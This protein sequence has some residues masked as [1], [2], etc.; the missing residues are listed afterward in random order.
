MGS[1]QFLIFLDIFITS[2]GKK[3]HFVFKE[4]FDIIIL[5]TRNEK[6]KQQDEILSLFQIQ[7]SFLLLCSISS[8]HYYFPQRYFYW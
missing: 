8:F 3:E 5:Q 1:E 2:M 6:L 4:N 7:T